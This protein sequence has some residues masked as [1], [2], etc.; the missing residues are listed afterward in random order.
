MSVQDHTRYADDV[1]AYL[2]GALEPHEE[3]AFENHLDACAICQEEV[4]RLEVARD[5]LPQSVEPVEPPPELKAALMAT[6]VEE[7]RQRSLEG[8]APAPAARSSRRSR[9]RDLLVA[10]PAFAAAAAATVLAIGIAA[11][12]L[13]GAL[14]GDGGGGETRVVAAQV[15]RVRQP[16]ATARLVVPEAAYDKGGAMLRVSGMQ[17]PPAGHVYEVWLKRGNRIVRSSLFA[18]AHD[19][20]GAAAIPERLRGVDTI[21]VTREPN[22]GSDAPSEAPVVTVQVPA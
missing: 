8:S 15:D 12:A 1:G 22:G 16:A 20:S 4:E 2:L 10:R 14:G 3:Q 9:W 7:A 6:V 17:Q 21:M 18:V 11:G 19:G 5:A 13:A